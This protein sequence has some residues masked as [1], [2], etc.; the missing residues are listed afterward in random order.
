[1]LCLIP[2]VQLLKCFCWPHSKL[3]QL[4]TCFH[5]V[6]G[7]MRVENDPPLSGQRHSPK[8]KLTELKDNW[9]LGFICGWWFVWNGKGL[10]G[11]CDTVNYGGKLEG[12]S[13]EENQ[14][15]KVGPVGGKSLQVSR[16]G[17]RWWR[18]TLGGQKCM[19]REVGRL[20]RF[21]P[22]P[23]SC[24]SPW[25]NPLPDVDFRAVIQSKPIRASVRRPPSIKRETAVTQ[26]SH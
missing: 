18:R 6:E 17:N 13:E 21:D 19:K 9:H 2:T 3:L 25:A 7:L 20:D 10:E 26:A 5:G 12:W 11:Q 23:L 16:G 24:A 14:G 4:T 22:I 8:Q 15:W 1:M